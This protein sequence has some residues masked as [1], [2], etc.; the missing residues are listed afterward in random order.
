[1][2]EEERMNVEIPSQVEEVGQVRQDGK[3][4]QGAQ[5]AQVT[6]LGDPIHMCK[7]V[8]R[9]QRCIIGI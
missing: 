9:F 3:E 5:G 1:M 6:P 2:L 7:E 8:L 4:V